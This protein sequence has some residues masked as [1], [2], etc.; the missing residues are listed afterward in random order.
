MACE[1]FAWMQMPAFDGSARA[2]E[3]KLLRLFSA[4]G[5]IA[6]GGRRVRLR[7][8]ATWPWATQMTTAITRLQASA[9]G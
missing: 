8:A 2:W 4:A 7:L 6:R 1:L 5:R 9:P 3:P